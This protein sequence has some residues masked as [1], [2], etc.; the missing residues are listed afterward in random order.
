MMRHGHFSLF[1]KSISEIQR[2]A[3][4]ENMIKSE[5]ILRGAANG[6][7]IL[8]AVIG[9]YGCTEEIIEKLLI[10]LNPKGSMQRPLAGPSTKPLVKGVIE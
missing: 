5:Q 10:N 3:H 9:D 6:R 4:K 2:I 8:Q 1:W 7:L